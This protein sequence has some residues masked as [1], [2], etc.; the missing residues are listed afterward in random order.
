MPHKENQ[1][2]PKKPPITLTKVSKRFLPP[3]PILLEIGWDSRLGGSRWG[4][5]MKTF[6]SRPE[7]NKIEESH[8]GQQGDAGRGLH[9][10]REDSGQEEYAVEATFSGSTAASADV[11]IER[12]HRDTSWKPAFLSG[13]VPSKSIA[14]PGSAGCRGAEE[15]NTPC[16]DLSFVPF[17]NFAKSISLPPQIS[18]VSKPFGD[19]TSAGNKLL[20]VLGIGTG[21][22]RCTVRRIPV[23]YRPE[24][25]S[26]GYGASPPKQLVRPYSYGRNAAVYGCK[27]LVV[28]WKNSTLALQI[29]YE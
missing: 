27:F 5:R 25:W 29:P 28:C 2:T 20:N 15:G 11:S 16:P 17:V 12:V 6:K 13:T 9:K 22:T 26:Y 7:E 23:P 19:M 21:K 24:I 14:K 18:S 10:E 8:D 3:M 1:E 4:K